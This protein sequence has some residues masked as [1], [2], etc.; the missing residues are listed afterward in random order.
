MGFRDLRKFNIAM[1][2]KQGWRL[3]NNE[4]SLVTSLMKARYYP[5]SDFLNAEL[6]ANPSYMWRSILAA[7]DILKQGCRRRIGDGQSTRI[8]EVPWL[9]CRENG[10]LSTIM[11]PELENATVN[12]LMREG[13]NTW[14]EEILR[15]LFNDRDVNLIQ[16]IPLPMRQEQDSW[17]WPSDDKGLF[18]VRSCYR[19]LQGES[20]NVNSGFW[21]KLWSMQVPS[22]I[23]NFLWRACKLCL[24]TAVA[25][26]SKNVQIDVKCS[27]CRMY[28]EDAV[29]VLFLCSFAQ[30]VWESTGL[31]HL[32]QVLPQDTVFDVLKRV[33]DNSTQEQFVM[34]GL[35]C[36]S[37]WGRRNKWVWDKVQVSVFGAKSNALNLLNDWRQAR[38]EIHRPKPTSVNNSRTWN[39]PPTGWVKINI[40]AATFAD[41]NCSG[42]GC[43][44]RDDHGN[45]LRVRNRRVEHS[46]HPREAEALSLK[47]ALSWTKQMGYQWCIF[48]T[49]AKLLANACKGEQ[50][51]SYFHTIVRDCIEFFKHFECVLIEYV[52]R[53]ANGVAHRL[54]RATHSESGV[55]EWANVVPSF[56][57][58]AIVFDSI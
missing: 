50:G 12:G 40:D 35:F 33:W 45:F 26:V 29:H 56:L 57:S 58:D 51:R 44:V 19:M 17:F 23:V 38:Q 25:L 55:K 14:D 18:T 15:D 49:D 1:L 46:L 2:A 32:V 42:M 21:K 39:A 43:V 41:I 9:P 13:E 53:S 48:E 5:R 36:W 22:K 30:S 4:N 3:L 24:P 8:W 47:E 7:Q 27:W 52:S 54:A 11:P 20:V 37:L 28:N 10:N 34:V 6:G 31:G 16:K